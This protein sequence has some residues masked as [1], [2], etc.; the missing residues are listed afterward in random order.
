MRCIGY[1]V[2]L[3]FIAGCTSKP[4]SDHVQ[5]VNVTRT[6]FTTDA[7]WFITWSPLAAG[8]TSR[9]TL[10]LTHLNPT[11]VPVADADLSVT[12]IQG[13]EGIKV[14]KVVT[15]APG[16]YSFMLQPLHTGTGKLIL[17][18]SGTAAGEIT[19]EDV[20]VSDETG[21]RSVT[22][23]ADPYMHISKQKLWH[24]QIGTEVAVEKP[25]YHAIKAAGQIVPAPGQDVTIS[26][27]TAGILHYSG[28]HLTPGTLINAG[29]E[30]FRISGGFV[31][32][33]ENID[34]VISQARQSLNIA[35]EELNR[36]KQLYDDRLITKDKYQRALLECQNLQVQLKN[37]SKNYNS[38]GNRLSTPV[39]GYIRD[40]FASEG[41]Y[42]AVGE[43]LA[44]ISRNQK[45]ILQANVSL[46]DAQLIPHISHASFTTG[47]SQQVYTTA[48]KTGT[49]STGKLTTVN[50]S[51]MP[52][53][54]AMD[55]Q[56][57]LLPGMIVQTSLYT[58]ESRNAIAVPREALIEEQN[59]F[60]LYVQKDGEH[61]EKR[62]VFTG[63]TNHDL[64]EVTSGLFKGERVVTIGA[65]RLN[66]AL[67][68]APA[69]VHD[70]AH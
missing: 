20:P 17:S 14:K 53:Y 33:T 28:N 40:V 64:V 49:L 69:P 24:L 45:V 60:Y 4:G 15:E 18:R 25:I 39:T 63:T 47:T 11:A 56:P 58:K 50:S 55:H 70:H 38:S 42:V 43:P 61:F 34:I 44:T 16:I 21:S 37:L 10:C 23:D 41:Q 67:S 62:Q 12:F 36:A 9:F 13:D 19:I 5:V 32:S 2:I 3:I 57:D 54:F 6:V 35:Q 52:V 7:E 26:A 48:A 59:R 1:F 31:N 27:T 51:W 66:T 46:R 65:Y 30:L 68:V 8:K 22:T 29:Q